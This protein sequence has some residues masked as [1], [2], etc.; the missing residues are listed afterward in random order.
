MI[1]CLTLNAAIDKT[2]I[3][4]PFRLNEIHRP[5]QLLALPGGKGCNVARALKTLGETP[6]VSGYVGGFAGQ[7]I[8]SGLRREGIQ[9]SFVHTEGESR[10]C[11]SI[12][13]PE[14]RTLTE[15]YERGE[16]IPPD[17]LDELRE[18]F[19]A[20]V[21]GCDFVALCGSLPAG[22]PTDFYAQLIEIAGAAGVRAVLDTSGDALKAGVQAHPF[23]IKPNHREFLDLLGKAD[24]NLDQA[25]SELARQYVTNVVLS[26]GA[27]G[28]LLATP[29]GRCFHARPPQAEV[30]T[31]VGS[32][33]C[34]LAG[35]LYGQTHG[36]PLDQSLRYG[37]AAGTANTLQ[38]GA[39]IFAIEDFERILAQID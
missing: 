32:G 39:G 5:Q 26:L 1:L 7:F 10:T 20:L 29:D 2:A 6:T 36:L 18:H 9:T 25:A 35:L 15:L 3:V 16:S 34:L 24:A 22:V 12:Y 14:A 21:T 30:V 11:L 31:A 28:A 8:E 38:L 4:S 23:L 37:V 17:K 19:R 33:D 27:D 13:D